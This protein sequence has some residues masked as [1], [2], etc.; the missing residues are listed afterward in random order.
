MGDSNINIV[1]DLMKMGLSER[2]AKVYRV[3]IGVDE[4]T[5]SGIPKFTDIPRTKVY[6]VLTSLIKKGFCREVESTSGSQTYTAVDPRIALEGVMRVEEE[7]IT[8]LRTLND[9]LGGILFDLYSN[10]ALRLKDY[11]FVQ[12]LRGRQEI[13]NTYIAYRKSAEI[14][15]LELSTGSYAMQ[16]AEAKAEAEDNVRLLSKGMDIRV[17]YQTNEIGHDGND[18][19]HTLNLQNGLR[20]RVY[21]DVPVKMSLIDKKTILLPLSDPLLEAPNLT[22]LLIEHPGLYEVLKQAFESYWSKSEE[23]TLEMIE[24]KS[25]S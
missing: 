3:L 5:A 1:Q 10:S 6:E 19:F 25:K 2:E 24:G 7:R 18:Y 11:D 4:I 21:P 23:M 20:A 9:T 22:V 15:I 16:D 17:I 14:E 12:I 8:G 13:V